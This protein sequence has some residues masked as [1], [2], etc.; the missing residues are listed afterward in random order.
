M[1]RTHYKR[2]W[3]RVASTPKD[4]LVEPDLP[5]ERWAPIPGYADY[6]V[7]D[8]GRV[9]S[10][11]RVVPYVDGRMRRCRGRLLKLSPNNDNGPHLV[12]ALGHDKQFK[13][14]LVHR[15]VLL[16]FVG[17]CPDGMEGC[18]NNGDSL[19]NRLTNLRWDNRSGNML[20]AVRHGTHSKTRRTH[21]PRGH[22]LAEPNLKASASKRG[23][24]TCLTCHRTQANEQTAK[25]LGLPFD[26]EARA[27]Y[28]YARIM[29]ADRAT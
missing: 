24:R 22:V 11:D 5:G 26:F 9:R 17:P 10:L 1:C 28:H 19:D 4:R 20:D 13:G 7:S 3:A 21:C 6:E 29:G 23:Y 18:H 25:R 2:Q 12:V 16:A 27:A 8:Q 15:L 14:H